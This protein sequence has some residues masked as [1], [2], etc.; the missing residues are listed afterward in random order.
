[1]VIDLLF[2]IQFDEQD[3]NQSDTQNWLFLMSDKLILVTALAIWISTSAMA[4][5][6]PCLPLWLLTQLHPK[7][8]QLGTV[9]IPDSLGYLVGTNFFGSISFRCGQIKTAVAALMLVGV[10][11][12]VIPSA[13]SVSSLIVPHF[14][15]GLGIGI[16]D[17]SL[18]PL[19]ASIVD[20]KTLDDGSGSTDLTTNYG[21][22]YAIQQTAVS[23]AY[24]VAPFLG[25][26]L[27]KVLGFPSLMR[28]LGIV[29]FL[30][31]PFLVF[32]TMRINLVV[33]P[34]II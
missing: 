18:V 15:L 12:C 5:L 14:G 7:K 6:E 33:R 25:G 9:F 8:W 22:V 26:E 28:I 20:S 30:Y 21:S 11:C 17:A 27:T 24:S 1:M 10:S 34:K 29:N 2:S 19:M 13:T 4:I 31:G 16:V 3:T 23:L 32:M